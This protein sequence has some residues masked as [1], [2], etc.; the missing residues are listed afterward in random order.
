MQS[1]FI[2]EILPKRTDIRLRHH[3]YSQL[4]EKLP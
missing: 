4:R 2:D 3:Q 1:F